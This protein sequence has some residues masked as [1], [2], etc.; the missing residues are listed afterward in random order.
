MELIREGEINSFDVKRGKAR[1]IYRD[2]DNKVSDWLHILV[3]FSDS[4]SDNYNL[5]VGQSV[6]VLSLPDMQ[7]QGYIL[8]CPMRPSSIVEGEV[9][10]T[11]ADGGF[12][13]YSNGV[14]TINPVSKVVINANIEI[15]GDLKVSGTTITGGNINLNTHKHSGVAQGRAKTGGPE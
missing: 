7:E 10:R 3:P 2:R 12:Y 13:S 1:V 6:L 9:K 14:L 4:H 8:G 11:F 5:S 15:N